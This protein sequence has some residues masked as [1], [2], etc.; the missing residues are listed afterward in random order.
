MVPKD[1]KKKLF[2]TST[3]DQVQGDHVLKSTGGSACVYVL[4][5]CWLNM[6]GLLFFI[7]KGLDYYDGCFLFPPSYFHV[8]L[9]L[10]FHTETRSARVGFK[11]L[12]FTTSKNRGE[13]E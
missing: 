4:D 9:H 7:M 1:A 3:Q 12:L 13:G 10:D 8:F 6:M 5:T 2:F 11:Y